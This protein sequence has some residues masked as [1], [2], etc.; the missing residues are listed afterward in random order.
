MAQ[1]K[2]V[3]DLK[4]DAWNIYK[5]VSRRV[6]QYT[7]NLTPLETKARLECALIEVDGH[8]DSWVKGLYTAGRGGHKQRSLGPAW[9]CDA[10]R[11]H[12]EL[13][14]QGALCFKLTMPPFVDTA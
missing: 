5:Q 1:L 10:R 2:N 9:L 4:K 14:C 6:K 8:V 13:S 3:D 11:G 12:K 7:L